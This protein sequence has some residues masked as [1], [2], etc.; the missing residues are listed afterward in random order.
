MSKYTDNMLSQMRKA[1]PIDM[2][3]AVALASDFGLP[4]RSV[5]SK[6]TS[7]D[8]VVYLAKP[9]TK[10]KK[11]GITKAQLA[12]NIRKALKLPAKDGDLSKVDLIAIQK[13]IVADVAN[14]SV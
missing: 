5:V 1:S 2:R 9:K 8:D 13:A 6:A 4:V 10:A 3:K 12:D 14:A 11:D 7:M